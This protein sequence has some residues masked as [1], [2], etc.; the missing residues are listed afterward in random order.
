[1]TRLSTRSPW[2]GLGALCLGLFM[3]LLDTTI[4][5]I[6][7]PNM[8]TSLHAGLDQILWIVNIYILAYA[9]PLI[10][11]S[12]LGD[13]FGRKR[14]YVTGLVVFT[15]ASAL[16][17][18]ADT[19]GSLIAARALQGVGA[20]LMNPQTLA[21]ISVLFPAEKRGAA[22]GMWSAVAGVSTIAGP[23]LGGL[24]VEKLD[25][26]W[27]FFVNVPVGAVGLLLV[28]LW[29]PESRTATAHR[30]DPLG[31]VLLTGALAAVTFGLLEGS[32]YHWGTIAGPLSIP[33]LLG[34]GCVLLAA[35]VLVQLRSTDPLVPL[36]LFAHRNFALANVVATAVGFAMVSLLPLMIFLQGVLGLTP[37][38]A[39]LLT[40]P[41]SVI[42]SA[43]AP[44]AGF[45]ADRTGGKYLLMAGLL[46]FA[47]GIGAAAL[48]AKPDISSWWVLPAVAVLGVGIGLL[49]TSMTTVAVGDVT[50]E[51]SG[52]ASGVFNTTRQLGQALGTAAVGALL[53]STLHHS[54]GDEATRLS[55]QLPDAY[56][57]GFVKAITATGDNPLYV[58][59]PKH[60]GVPGPVGEQLRQ[61]G[62]EA[63]GNAFVEAMRW[64][65]LL[66]L[67]FTLLAAVFC[68]GLKPRRRTAG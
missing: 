6:A 50:P 36:G 38:Q 26:H 27:I 35:F 59:A 24:I 11:A 55:A 66:P 12:R 67:G 30:F 15:V 31:V 5:N 25:W 7:V 17:G 23:L 9:V 8:L 48:V 60:I 2:L 58:Q 29:V 19:G 4:V 37:L 44:F 57:A 42:A 52:A 53:Q 32:R 54:L 3:I 49:F 47:A 56:R 65:L 1:M 68:F 34:G 45:R 14:L 46:S 64:T 18:L 41:A 43:I 20:A 51:L 13:R 22:F 40:A 21:F 61:L 63:F 28:L 10:V 62:T 33:L 16:C 39:G